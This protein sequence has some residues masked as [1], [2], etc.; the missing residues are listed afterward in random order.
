MIDSLYVSCFDFFPLERE[1]QPQG[2]ATQSVKGTTMGSLRH[3][4]RELS[5][6]EDPSATMRLVVVAD[7]HGQPHPQALSLIEQL[8]PD[9]ILHAGDIGRLGFLDELA[10]RAPTIAVRGNVDSR[11]SALY[12]II[13]VDLVEAR[14]SRLRLLLTHIAIARTRLRRDI[15]D[16]AFLREAQMV[17][18]GHSHVPWLGRDGGVAVL[19]PGSIGPRR[20]S[21][22]ITLATIDV[23]RD[24]VT[25]GHWDC[26]TLQRWTP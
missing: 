9:A 11:A 12:D 14:E 26:E 6:P 20:F 13:T 10:Q 21:L 2:A 23:A 22:P 18:C 1:A 24:G 7:S 25:M 5:L 15:R 19:N 8:A 16:L 4:S 17:V 3:Q